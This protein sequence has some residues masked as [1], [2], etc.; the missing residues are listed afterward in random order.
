MEPILIISNKKIHFGT[1]EMAMV[2]MGN[3]STWLNDI[4]FFLKEWK[5][6]EKIISLQTSGSTGAPKT[7][8]VT[9]DQMTYSAQVTLKAFGLQ[10]G[11][12]ALLNLPAKYIAGKMMLVRALEGGLS[13]Y[14]IPPTHHVQ[15][16]S[17][18][19]FDFVALTPAQVSAMIDKNFDLTSFKKILIGGAP[20]S[21]N[22][23]RTLQKIESDIRISFGMTET[24]SHF[25]LAKVKPDTDYP[26]YE[27]LPGVKFKTNEQEELIVRYPDMGF[28][29]LSTNDRVKLLSPKS[30]QWLGRNDWVI[31]SGGVKISAEEIEDKISHLIQGNYFVFGKSDDV[32]GFLPCLV[33]EKDSENESNLHLEMAKILSKLELPREIFTVDKILKT[34]NGKIDRKITL[35]TYNLL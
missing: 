15:E 25:A 24:L 2:S 17:K 19:D 10:E 4:Y 20:V 23:Y 12:T 6:K 34:H 31:N 9:R 26:I 8:R 29:N 33:V 30:F 5:N 14:A 16:L 21:Q 22:L 35:S 18:T 13:L 7:I 27:A 3:E 11:N 1:I 28:T 32:F